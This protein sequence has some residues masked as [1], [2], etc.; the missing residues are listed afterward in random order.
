[1]LLLLFK[2]AILYRKR[3]ETLFLFLNSIE[4]VAKK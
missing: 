1:M 4:I 3:R 2:E